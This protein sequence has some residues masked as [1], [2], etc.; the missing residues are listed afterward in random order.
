MR[1]G[2]LAI[3]CAVVA[4]ASSAWAQDQGG[5]GVVCNVKVLS[6]KVLDVS[7]LEAWKKSYI[8]EGMTDQE[9]A[10]AVWRTVVTYQHQDAPPVEYLQAGGK[11]ILVDPI[12]MFNVYGY[13]FCS[14]AASEVCELGKIAGLKCR[15][16][17]IRNHNVMELGYDNSW[18][19]FDASL[20]NYFPKPD[21]TIASIEEVSGAIKAWLD[22]HPDL[23]GN[24]KKLQAFHFAD[25][26]QGWRKGPEL[27]AKCP[28]YTSNGWWPA[29]THG[30]YST[31]QEY[32]CKPYLQQD[33]PSLSYSVNIQLRQGEKL[34]R[35][36]SNKGLHSSMDGGGGAP[37]CAKAVT[38]KEP[39]LHTPQFG[40]IAP[41]RVGNG[42][43]EYD[44]MA[45]KSL[46]TTAL[47]FDNLAF[48]GGKAR[49]KDAAKP[50]V[51]VVRMPTSYVY[52]TGTMDLK[53]AMS[54]GGSIAVS[55]SDNNG[56]DWK[57]VTK[58]DKAGDQNVDLSK[59]VLRRYDYR[60]KF[61]FNGAGAGLDA[62]KIKHDIQHS[63]RPLPA[64]GQ[65]ENTITFS[66]GPQLSTMRLDGTVGDFGEK[67]VRYTDFH[68]EVDKLNKQLGGKGSITFPFETPGELKSIRAGCFYRGPADSYEVQLSYD[69]GKTF[70]TVSTTPNLS[71]DNCN[72][73]NP[74]VTDLPAGLKT[75]QVR[76]LA[77]GAAAMN[78]YWI[79]ADYKPAAAGFRPVKVTY[80][81]EEDGKEKTDVHVAKTPEDTYKINCETKPTMKNIVLELAD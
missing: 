43:L 28:W 36:W 47:T 77:K 66:A 12:K 22:E 13:S 6:D 44:A 67:Q 7:S 24:G 68:P 16:W 45:D 15:G 76:Y 26:K 73:L 48:D 52:L 72:S 59:R 31:M 50:G 63:Q 33:S 5:A 58:I 21:G 81:W 39:L 37:G 40:D 23:K 55:F 32:D 75:A 1:S 80:V 2:S 60:L 61:E 18:H 64:L 74:T 62:L 20:I 53:A 71:G 3:L 65:G 69:G 34:T 35:N 11:G 8:K 41:G 27:L 79:V 10:I 49:I 17:A 54:D 38:G 46:P 9:K 70:T 25:Q 19:L 51:M 30:W 29:K 78:T 56:L 42:L 4:V 57:E 14:V